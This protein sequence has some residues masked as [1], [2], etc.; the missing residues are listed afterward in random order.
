MAKI[1]GKD[2]IGVIT[3][4]RLVKLQKKTVT[5][6]ASA[7][8]V[9]PDTGYDGMSEVIINKYVSKSQKKTVTP[10][11]TVQVIT[12]DAGYDGLSEVTVGVGYTNS[13]ASYLDKSLTKITAD[14]LSTIDTIPRSAFSGFENLS[15]VS[16]PD[17]IKVISGQAFYRCESL[18]TITLPDTIEE[19][20]AGAFSYSTKLASI[21][22]PSNLK[23]LGTNAFGGTAWQNN[24]G[25]GIIYFGKILYTRSYY[26]GQYPADVTQ[27]TIKSDTIALACNALSG[28]GHIPSIEKITI[29]KSVKY[30][31]EECLYRSSALK[32]VTF[33]NDSQLDEIDDYAFQECTALTSIEIPQNV[34]KIGFGV[35]SDSGLTDIVFKGSKLKAVVGSFYGAKKLKNVTLPTGLE[36]LGNQSFE[37]CTAL[38]SIEIPSSVKLMGTQVFRG[39]TSLTSV[40]FA[41]NSQVTKIDSWTFQDCTS[42]TSLEIPSSVTLIDY[43]A[44]SNMGSPSNKTTIIIHATVPPTLDTP[45]AGETPN[46][47][48]I[49]VPKGYGNTYKSDWCWGAYADLI[50]EATE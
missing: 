46:I 34:T 20:G 25:Q 3:K 23:K 44:F 15:E 37:D 19:L 26:Y 2:I 10:K 6:T 45:F 49:V 39:C 9:K 4:G 38:T 33:E 16:I 18:E 21:N 27:P 5:P 31:G 1:N 43:G 40:S 22:V 32:S 7:Q 29:P 47:N 12:P 41:E 8:T 14:D 28:S 36:T 42:L 13:I 30:L 24:Q 50:V 48:Q 17:N 35:F 11:A